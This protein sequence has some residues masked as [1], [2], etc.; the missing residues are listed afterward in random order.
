[1]INVRYDIRSTKPDAPIYSS[2]D[3][4]LAKVEL[5]D[6]QRK[7]KPGDIIYLNTTVE[8][9]EPLTP[10]ERFLLLVYDT[11]CL[12][13]IYFDN[14]R[15]HE[16]LKAAFAK[17]SYLDKWLKTARNTLDASGNENRLK[18]LPDTSPKKLH[19][20]FFLLVESWRKAW[21]EYFAYKKLADKDPAIEA[22]MKKK[23]FDY[24]KAIDTYII[25]TLNL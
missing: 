17:E 18:A 25:Q 7:A 11:R 21:H 3:R 15:K 9:K 19:Y 5:A 13:R 2:Y 20:T 12:Q 23:C 6:Q 22:E 24:E 16:D 4:T 14:G 10:P 8:P 1:M